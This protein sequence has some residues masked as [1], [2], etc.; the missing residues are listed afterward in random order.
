[1]SPLTL[2]EL[3]L[4]Q[5][6]LAHR[7]ERLRAEWRTLP[8]G[9]RSLAMGKRVQDYQTRADDYLAIIRVAEGMS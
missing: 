2:S 8:T 9:S 1:M 6:D 5:A 4:M 3:R 7:A